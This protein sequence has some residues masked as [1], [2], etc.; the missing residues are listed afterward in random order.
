MRANALDEQ[1]DYFSFFEKE[2]NPII[3]ELKH[4]ILK[5]RPRD[6]VILATN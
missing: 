3:K 4:A 6:I 5:A 2:M 1:L